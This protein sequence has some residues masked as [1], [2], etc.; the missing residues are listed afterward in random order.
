MPPKYHEFTREE[1]YEL[2]WSKPMRKL[3]A[4]L[5]VSD[6]GLAKA[7][8]RHDIP[9]PARG[10]WAKRAAGRRVSQQPLPPRAPGCSDDVVIGRP[11][12]WGHQDVD[13]D[14]PIPELPTF[15]ESLGA[16]RARLLEQARM[17]RSPKTLSNPHVQ[18]SR[19]IEDEKA[20]QEKISTERYVFSWDRPRFDSP[21]GRRKLRVLNALFSGLSS[22]NCTPAVRG[23]DELELSIKV[24]EQYVAFELTE[25]G[26]SSSSRRGRPRT[27]LELSIQQAEPNDEITWKW[28]DGNEERLEQ[29]IPNIIAEFVVVGEHQ[30]RWR[31]LA[32]HE[33]YVRMKAEHEA[34][35]ARALEEA[36]RQREEAKRRE[37]QARIDA[38]LSQARD[39]ENANTIRAYV[40]SVR[41][42]MSEEDLSSDRKD[43][44]LWTS[45][46]LSQADQLDPVWSGTYRQLV[47]EISPAGTSSKL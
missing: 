36:A 38:L 16:L 6:V 39:Y 5:G 44:E 46:A 41:A 19:L 40:A 7:C 42:K 11:T 18:I 30:Y 14:A 28:R 45:W 32:Q 22:F 21:I 27:Q 43:I 13:W 15:T 12:Y 29:Q 23:R 33:W 37:E 17:L 35:R 1:L 8:R 47:P 20:R 31:V 24:G 4:E 34:E 10:Y 2:V 25:I 9:R 3:A 26:K